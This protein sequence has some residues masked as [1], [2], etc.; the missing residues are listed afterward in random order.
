[1][2]LQTNP[3]NTSSLTTSPKVK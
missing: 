3:L 2:L 1:M